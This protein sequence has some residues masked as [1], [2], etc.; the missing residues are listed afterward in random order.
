MKRI[1]A[2]AG[3]TLRYVGGYGMSR[4]SWRLVRAMAACTSCAAASM[5]RSRANCRVTFVLPWELD[6][7]MESTPAMVEN[8]FSS[9]VATDE[10]IVSGFAP[11]KDALT[12]MVGKSTFG[13]SLTGS[14]S[15]DI[16][17]KNKI[18]AMTIVVM[19]GR[20]MNG[21]QTFIAPRSARP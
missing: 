6:E 11:G 4:G 20:R 19:T 16:R 12:E 9:G 14:R 21:P 15:Y 8:S 7:V 5:L 1:G 13:R 2:S 18:P 17:P 3:L 10:A